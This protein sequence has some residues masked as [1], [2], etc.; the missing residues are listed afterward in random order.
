[1][2]F[3]VFEAPNGAARPSLVYCG[4]DTDAKEVA[5]KLIRDV[6]F[7]PLDVGPLKIAPYMEPFGL[8]VA[9]VAYEG[10][11]GPEVAYQFERF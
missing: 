1:V 11:G 4:D 9:R 6:G 10:E 2:L 3:D 5:A 7:E 8:L